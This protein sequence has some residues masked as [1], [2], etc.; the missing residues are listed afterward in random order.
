MAHMFSVD[1]MVP[2]IIIINNIKSKILVT[3]KLTPIEHHKLRCPYT[4]FKYLMP[5]KSFIFVKF[6]TQK[7]Y[8]LRVKINLS[9]S[10]KK[11]KS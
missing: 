8:F 10:H 7:K 4:S 5:R 3:T 9:Q 11:S 2:Q 6:A 1:N